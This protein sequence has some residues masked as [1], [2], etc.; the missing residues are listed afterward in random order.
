MWFCNICDKTNFIK[1]KSKQINSQSQKHKDNFSVV[2]KQYG[3]IRPD[4]NRLNSINDDC[5]TDC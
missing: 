5:A 3:F 1:V 2:L 4:S